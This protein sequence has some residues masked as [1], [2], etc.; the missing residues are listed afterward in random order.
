MVEAPSDLEAGFGAAASSV[1][2]SAVVIGA[3]D[4][5]AAA[6]RR[7]GVETAE[8]FDAPRS[9]PDVAVFVTADTRGTSLAA[10]SAASFREDV[11]GDLK[12]AFV[13]LKRATDA[14]RSRGGG[15]SVVFVAPKSLQ[16]AHDTIRQGLRLLV[17]AAALELGAER[18]RV[19][20]VL[21]AEPAT[22]GDVA[23]AVAFLASDRALF[24]TGA[25]LVVDGGRA[26]R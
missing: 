12:A 23:E 9:R 1:A 21:P 15:G 2:R 20:I 6:L 11:G 7:D 16:T 22:P 3:G 24:V 4:A 25:D 17:K 10:D 26:A 18:I 14:I 8:T 19:N 5:V 13:F